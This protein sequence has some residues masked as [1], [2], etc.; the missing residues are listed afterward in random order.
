MVSGKRSR[1]AMTIYACLRGCQEER[2]FATSRDA[3]GRRVRS[4]ESGTN[5]ARLPESA[6]TSV[7]RTT[8]GGVVREEGVRFSSLARGREATTAVLLPLRT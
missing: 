4:G 3:L 6:S 1:F 8:G 7:R 2:P 5:M